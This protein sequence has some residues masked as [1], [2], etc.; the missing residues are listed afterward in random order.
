MEAGH[1]EI[2][3]QE[4]PTGQRARLTTSI[5]T[6]P[7][8]DFPAASFGAILCS[9][10]LHFLLA[11]EIRATLGKMHRWLRPEGRLFLVAD[12]PYSGFWFRSAPAYEARKA[13]GE[14][15]PGLIEDIAAYHPT[16]QVPPGMLPYLNP[17][18]PDILT[19]ECHRAGFVV[20]EA[21]FIYRQGMPGRDDRRHAWAIAVRPGTAP[22]NNK[23]KS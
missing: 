20:E 19:R 9:R 23:G 10:V 16:G 1:L 2:L 17:L 18:D 14:E 22:L 5:G 3:E 11:E 13:A 6:L 15:W 21:D 8:V 4:V 7:E 12:T